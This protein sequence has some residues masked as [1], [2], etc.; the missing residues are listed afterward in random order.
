MIDICIFAQLD[1][2]ADALLGGLVGNVRD[3]RRLFCLNKCVKS[4][5]NLPIPAPIMV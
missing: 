5:R 2:D 4:L 1:D 3:I